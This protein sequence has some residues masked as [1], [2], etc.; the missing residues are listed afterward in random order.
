MNAG[1]TGATT[2]MTSGISMVTN[3]TPNHG[4]E[5]VVVGNDFDRALNHHMRP[6]PHQLYSLSAMKSG[7]Q[8]LFK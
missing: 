2:H 6:K 7:S 3:A 4:S 5:K 8:D 1:I